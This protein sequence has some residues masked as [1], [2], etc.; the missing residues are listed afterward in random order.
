LP[1]GPGIGPVGNDQ[2]G[3]HRL[4][5]SLPILVI[6]GGI[7][8]ITA[9]VEIAETGGEVVLVEKAP[10][11]GGNVASFNNY[12]PK[13]CPPAC[14]LEINFRR[15]RSNPRIRCMVG[16]EI[17]A[18]EGTAGDFRV[19][20][21]SGPALINDLCT[22]CGICAEVCP[23]DRPP[24]KAVYIPGGVVFPLKYTIDRDICRG[25]ACGECMEAC[26]YDAIRLDAVTTRT[27]LGAHSIIVATGWHLYDASRIENYGYST[28][29][30]VITNLEFEQMLSGNRMHD[31]KLARPS[32]GQMP[33]RVA[34]VQCAGSRDLNHLPY[35]SAVCCPASIKHALTLAELY[36]EVQVEVFY[37]DLRLTG[38]NE[39]LLVKAGQAPSISF[40]RG[41]V[42]RI[43]PGGADGG[44]ILEVEDMMS[45]T[46]RRD[47]FDLVVLATGLVPNRIGP[48]L[49]TGEYGFYDKDQ[50]PGI[51]V[52][53][54][55]KRPMD[56]SS[57]VKDATAVALRALKGY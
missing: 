11:L 38:R 9:A 26:P 55:C 5:H 43:T 50:R 40:T 33:S 23:V 46:L 18:I 20:V 32:D 27:E 53:A 30:D 10:Y 4:N 37:I 7:G 29:P 41:K 31:H 44:L 1:V 51:Y 39:D 35:C 21:E 57:S 56:V 52:A 16:S 8:G 48:S 6:G 34:F 49:N 47:L 3:Y 17:T 24:G 22:S 19:T 15:I 54:S 2:K 42:G 14:G 25:E 13:L 12:F 45:G 28:E 36:P